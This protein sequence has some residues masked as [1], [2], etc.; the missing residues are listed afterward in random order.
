MT[1][2]GQAEPVLP[3]ITP[4]KKLAAIS[5]LTLTAAGLL[6]AILWG[7]P[8]TLWAYHVHQAGIYMQ[9]GLSWPEE[10]YSDSL[11]QALNITS[12]ET[13][14]VHLDQAQAVRSQHYHAYR[15]E[16]HIYM[17]LGKWLLAESA[18]A[19]AIARAPNN[20]LVHFDQV[21]VYEQMMG[22]LAEDA[23]RQLWPQIR[24]RPT[25]L[26]SPT[27]K[28]VCV[29]PPEPSSCQFLY[30]RISLPVDGMLWEA[31][32][33]GLRGSQ[34]MEVD[35]ILPP[36][37]SAL[38]YLLAVWPQAEEEITGQVSA[39]LQIRREGDTAFTTLSSHDL[40]DSD[41]QGVWLPGVVSLAPW[42]GQA[43]TVRWQSRSQDYFIGWSQMTLGTT[44]ISSMVAR[45]P[46][47][48]WRQA[49]WA[50]GFDSSDTRALAAE[51]ENIGHSDQ[52]SAW[53]RRSKLL[54]SLGR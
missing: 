28:E 15:L 3:G 34:T 30:T 23:G 44:E 1:V 52:H 51:A 24:A 17:A 54:E 14:L 12:I 8:F 40:S 36:D 22:A 53:L 4:A 27:F 21:I 49:L 33:L 26:V 41:S 31:P 16:G 10:R 48:R 47:L 45:T 46:W 13:A 18:I 29:D 11:P 6:A 43:V 37:V 25:Q 42:A 19:A 39:Q 9:R 5:A 35:L 7:Y 38:S 20:P 2:T 50:G 32:F